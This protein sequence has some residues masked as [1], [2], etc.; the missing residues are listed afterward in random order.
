MVWLPGTGVS[1]GNAVACVMC[2]LHECLYNW[3]ASPLFMTC[4]V[5]FCPGWL[6]LAHT[7]AAAFAGSYVWVMLASSCFEKACAGLVI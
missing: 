5:L 2:A 3:A 4:L 6:C 7:S 1:G